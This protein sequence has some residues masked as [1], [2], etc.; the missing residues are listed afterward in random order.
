MDTLRVF[1]HEIFY[2]FESKRFLVVNNFFALLTLVSILAIILETV[3]S[4]APYQILFET[5]EYVTVFFFTLEY[6]GRIIANRK[7]AL[8]YMFSF[9]GL[10]DL[11]SIVPSYVG[12]ANLTFLKSARILRVL[13]LLLFI[14]LAILARLRKYHL[15]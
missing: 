14:R 13:R 1:T 6:L 10:I 5:V 4:L 11:L 7:D 8:S 12:I 15:K 9:F 2:N 3:H